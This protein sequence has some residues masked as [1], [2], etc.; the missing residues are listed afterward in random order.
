MIFFARRRAAGD[1]AP[2]LEGQNWIVTIHDR[3]GISD[4]PAVA[5]GGAL[6]GQLRAWDGTAFLVGIAYR[7]TGATWSPVTIRRW[8]GLQWVTLG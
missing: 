6:G 7:W 4:S 1:P 5:S 8:D 2:E 3:L